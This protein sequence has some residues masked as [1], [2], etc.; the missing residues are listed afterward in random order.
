MF[1]LFLHLARYVPN[2]TK[3]SIR[4]QCNI[5]DR[6]TTD[7]CSWKS[8]YERTSNGHIFITVLDRRM[9]TVDHP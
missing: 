7:L 2:V 5:E 6:P 3:R 9:V 8:L 4:D 1:H